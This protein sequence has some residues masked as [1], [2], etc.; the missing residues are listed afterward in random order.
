MTL[1]LYSWDIIELPKINVEDK[2]NNDWY[3]QVLLIIEVYLGVHMELGSTL[4]ISP[5]FL[6]K[7]ISNTRSFTIF[8]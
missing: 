2:N 7:Y 4:I 5:K 1:L 6:E 3:V 8:F